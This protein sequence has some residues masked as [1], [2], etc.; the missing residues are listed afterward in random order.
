MFASLGNGQ[1]QAAIRA[2]NPSKNHCFL[3]KASPHACIE[4]PQTFGDVLAGTP[5]PNNPYNR[6]TDTLA[7]LE[8]NAR[9][10]AVTVDAH[11]NMRVGGLSELAPRVEVVLAYTYQRWLEERQWPK[12]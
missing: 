3:L 1:A 12:F 6:D 9:L 5:C 8:W 4:L 11:R 10:M 2:G 7:R